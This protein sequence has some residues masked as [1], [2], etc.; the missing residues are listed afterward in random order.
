MIDHVTIAGRELKALEAAFAAAGLPATYGGAH[1]NGITHMSIV[2]FADGSYVELIST[3]SPGDPSPLWARHM[4]TAGSPSAWCVGTPDLTGQVSQLTSR[5][6]AVRGPV[7][8]TRTRN[9]G[10]VLEWDVAFLDEGEPGAVLPFLIQ[11]RTDRAL[12]VQPSEA[13]TASGVAGV[14]AVVIGCKDVKA[15]ATRFAKAYGWPDVSTST[16]VDDASLELRLLRVVGKPLILAQPLGAASWLARRLERFD[17]SP[18][19][20]LLRSD[21]W[22]DSESRLRFSA[23]STWFGETAHW[24][25]LPDLPDVRIGVVR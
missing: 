9:D 6:V 2:G 11:D 12:R 14:A 10:V 8:Y 3:L 4:A 25:R 21:N 13:V 24:L 17:E 23:R 15:T 1:S 22:R 19:A 20:F 5:G 7:P 16:Q 18:C